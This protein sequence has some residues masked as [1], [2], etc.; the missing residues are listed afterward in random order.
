M[1]AT[2]ILHRGDLYRAQGK[3]ISLIHSHAQT[4]LQKAAATLQ[5]ELT[6]GRAQHGATA[7]TP[8]QPPATDASAGGGST[9]GTPSAS[10]ARPT[11]AAALLCVRFRALAEPQLAPM[12]EELAKRTAQE[13]YRR[14]LSNI[15]A[16]FCAERAAVILPFVRQHISAIQ[17]T[18][19]LHDVARCARVHGTT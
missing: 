8:T 11:M 2:S 12:L 18:D 15:E 3:A 9:A 10:G 19:G 1:S 13:E 7:G 5:S 6:A 17:K 4:V 16:S 14:L